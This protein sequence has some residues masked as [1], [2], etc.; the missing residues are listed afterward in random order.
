MKADDEIG[1]RRHREFHR[2]ETNSA[3]G[4]TVTSSLPAK[5][6]ALSVFGSISK[7][8]AVMVPASA[9]TGRAGRAMWTDVKCRASVPK[10]F[11]R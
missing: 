11:D 9:L 8:G 7:M 2:I 5:V 1:E 6:S 4:G 10:A 3:P